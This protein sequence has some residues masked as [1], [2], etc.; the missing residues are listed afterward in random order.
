MASTAVPRV[1][2]HVIVSIPTMSGAGNIT[3][4]GP[5]EYR[6]L[7]HWHQCRSPGRAGAV[8][9]PGFVVRFLYQV[10]LVMVLEDLVSITWTMINIRHLLC[11]VGSPNSSGIDVATSVR[12]CACSERVIEGRLRADIASRGHKCK[13]GRASCRERVWR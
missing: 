10:V 4:I 7:G 5:R 1:Y 9:M 13:I 2:G 11:C 6:H 3:F 8:R 12:N